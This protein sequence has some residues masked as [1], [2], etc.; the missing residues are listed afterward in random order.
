MNRILK[1]EQECVNLRKVKGVPGTA[2]VCLLSSFLN[3]YLMNAYCVPG[4]GAGAAGIAS[5]GGTSPAGV[6][7]RLPRRDPGLCGSPENG[8]GY[9]VWN[10][11][12]QGVCLSF[13]GPGE[14]APGCVCAEEDVRVCVSQCLDQGH[15]LLHE[16]TLE[17]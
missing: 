1:D 14:Q 11:M 3:T 5:T 13:L 16:S 2:A 4:P 10:P 9:C 8:S 12:E 7:A 17:V 6:P 15:T